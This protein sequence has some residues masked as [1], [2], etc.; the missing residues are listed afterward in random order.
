MDPISAIGVAA[1]AVQFLDVSLKALRICREIRDDAQSSTEK[2][3]E[4]ENSARKLKESRT[5]LS[6]PPRSNVPR[7]IA[8]T[9]KQCAVHIDELV[10]VLE[11]VRGAGM[12]IGTAKATFRVMRERRTIE[13]LENLLNEKQ[14]TLDRL[15]IQD[16]W[17]V[18]LSISGTRIF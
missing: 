3:K 5:E 7:R 8:D 9:A 16:I 2:N 1:A 14:K 11:H 17:Y 13:K 18:D 4:L 6:T 15:L 10:R 12:K